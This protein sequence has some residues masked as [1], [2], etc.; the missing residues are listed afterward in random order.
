MKQQAT[1]QNQ[2]PNVTH[3]AFKM[4]EGAKSINSKMLSTYRGADNMKIKAIDSSVLKSNQSSSKI[5]K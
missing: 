5:I 2:S 4:S 1:S 3:D